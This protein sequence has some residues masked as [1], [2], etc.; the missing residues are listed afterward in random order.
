MERGKFLYT[1]RGVRSTH[2]RVCFSFVLIAPQNFQFLFYNGIE[3]VWVLKFLQIVFFS[4]IDF[5][6]FQKLL[7]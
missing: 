5:L 6:V 1:G 4:D 3:C 2:V 7:I